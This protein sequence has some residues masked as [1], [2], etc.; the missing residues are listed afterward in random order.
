MLACAHFT[1]KLAAR[2]LT[3][4]D[5][6]QVLR[7][8][9]HILCHGLAERSVDRTWR[10]DG[11]WRGLR[12]AADAL[13]LSLTHCEFCSAIMLQI[14]VLFL[15]SCDQLLSLIVTFLF[16]GEVSHSPTALKR[17]PRLNLLLRS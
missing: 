14:R 4:A 6:V 10:R 3:A 5:A 11:R 13:S 16:W 17:I 15:E 8:A 1:T 2:C 12:R 9:G 7:K